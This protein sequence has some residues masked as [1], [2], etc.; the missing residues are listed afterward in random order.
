MKYSFGTHDG[1][2][3]ADE[4][5]ALALLVV[6]KKVD[7]KKIIR[8][9]SLEVLESCE[10]VCDVGGI[11]EPEK[12][13]FDHHQISYQGPLS[14]AGMILKYLHDT[15]VL[16]AKE[17]HFFNNSLIKG[18]DAFDNGRVTSNLGYCS[19]SNIISNYLPIEHQVSREEMDRA[20]HKAVDFT[21]GHLKRLYERFGYNLSCR[22]LVEEAMKKYTDCLFFEKSI[23]W[24]ESFFDLNGEGHPALFI[25]MPSGEH[26]KLRGI[27]PSYEEKIK[28]RHFLPKKWEG[29][30]EEELQKVTNIPGA[31]FCHKGRFISVWKTKEDAI[32]AYQLVKKEENL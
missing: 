6:F 10:Y 23:P 24:M 16:N 5:T 26:W 13:R 17:Y 29:L 1:S 7:P 9:R 28:V 25:I 22:G 32:K 12:K 11:Y 20:F 2:F 19:F 30:L 3:H 31:I 4:V 15:D 21:I 27:P 14:S 18:V 8:T